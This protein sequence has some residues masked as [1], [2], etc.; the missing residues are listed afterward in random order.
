M[1]DAANA[2]INYNG[3]N[4]FMKYSVLSFVDITGGILVG[5]EVEWAPPVTFKWAGKEITVKNSLKNKFNPWAYDYTINVPKSNSS[6]TLVPVTLSTRVSSITIDD[7][8]VTY[9]SSNKIAVKD[10]QIITIK[11]TAL[12]NITTSTYKFKI[13]LV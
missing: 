4:N 1:S 9:K 3:G 7:K 2:N 8:K 6:I 5:K 10:N 12:D 11:V 13:A